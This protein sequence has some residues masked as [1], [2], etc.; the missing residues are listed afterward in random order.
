MKYPYRFSEGSSA[1]ADLRGDKGANFA[2][3]ARL[4]LPVPPASPSPWRPAAF[5][6]LHFGGIIA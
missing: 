1:M 2:E 6:F 3:I 5:R 4:G